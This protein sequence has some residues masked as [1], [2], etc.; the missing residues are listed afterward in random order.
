MGLLELALA[1]SNP[2]TSGVVGIASLTN[3]HARLREIAILQ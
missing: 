3:V 1:Y 2:P